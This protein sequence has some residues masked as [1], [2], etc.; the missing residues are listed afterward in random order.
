MTARLAQID[1]PVDFH[2]A[3]V[4]GKLASFQR[5][6]QAADHCSFSHPRASHDGHQA[7]RIVI[8]EVSDL[9]CFDQ[10][11]LKIIWRD[12]WRRIDKARGRFPR[13][14]F[15]RL[16]LALESALDVLLGL[17]FRRFGILY[18]LFLTFDLVGQFV[19]FCF[20]PRLV[21]RSGAAQISCGIGIDDV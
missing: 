18:D 21:I 15:L 16:T 5:L 17:L 1:D 2:L 10:T 13:H 7:L 3:E 8:E 14:R 4:I 20:N 6:E 9:L 11:I 12:P 19:E